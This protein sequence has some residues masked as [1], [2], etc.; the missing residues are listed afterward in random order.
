MEDNTLYF[1]AYNEIFM[2]TK[3]TYFDRNRLYGGFGYRFSKNIRAEIG[4]MNQT[5]NGGSRNQLNIITFVNL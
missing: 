2:N 4:V 5:T 3:Q 1:S